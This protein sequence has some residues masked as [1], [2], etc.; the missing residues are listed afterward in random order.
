MRFEL[1][2]D[3]IILYP[4]SPL[5]VDLIERWE[6]RGFHACDMAI[7]VGECGVKRY[8]FGLKIKVMK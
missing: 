3:G 8:P 7:V 1:R 2:L 6:K 4:E 5:D